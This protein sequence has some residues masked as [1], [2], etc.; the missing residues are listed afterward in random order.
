[1]HL[2]RRAFPILC[3]LLLPLQ[4]A[5]Q[6]P[7][8]LDA[9]PDVILRALSLEEK[10]GEMT[11]ITIQAVSSVKGSSTVAQQLDSARLEEFI[12]RRNVGSL[13]NVWD[14][15]L[16]PAQWVRFTTTIQRFASRRRVPVPVLFGIDAVHGHQYMTG[17]TIFPQNIAMAATWDPPLVAQANRITAMETRASGVAW[18]FAPVLDLGR[19]PL[20]SR[21]YETFGEDVLLATRMGTASV[22][23]LQHD[24]PTAPDPL[25]V[26]ASAKHFLGYS[27]PLNGRDRTTAWIP[28][29]QLREYFLPTFAA[30]INAGVQ[31]VMVNSGDVNGIPVHASRALLTDL[32]RTELGFTGVVI[33]DWEDIVRLQTVHRVARTRLDAVRMA[34]D[35]G[36][37]VS[38]V[39]YDV[40]FIDD[41]LSLV[42]SGAITE[43][44]VD[45][46][47]RRMIRLKLALG[48]FDH[49]G[50]WPARLADAN[51]ADSRAVSRR[52]AEEAITLLKNARGLL[53]LSHGTRVLVTGPAATSL[54]AQHGGW[55]Y[56][57]QGRDTTMY[58]AEVHTLLDA[59]RLSAGADH[60]LYRLGSTFSEPRDIA[61]AVA[62]ARQVDVAIIALGE[63]AVAEKPGDIEDLTLDAAQ[64]RL[65]QAIEATGTPVVIVLF[66]N[67]P[68]VI[69]DIVDGA[70]AVLTGYETGPY[71]G[72]AMA[73]VLFGEVNPS[74]KLPFTY[75]RRANDI[76]HYDRLASAEAAPDF[77]QNGYHPEWD[78]GH[79]LSYTEFTY[80]S[81]AIDRTPV[82]V[83]DSVTVRVTLRNAGRRQGTEVVQLYVRQL[84]ASVDPPM[85]R[86]RDFRR[87][88]LSPG[89]RATVTFRLPIQQLAF[90][91][92]DNRMT[93]EPGEFQLLVAGLRAPLVVQ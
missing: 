33:S 63:N 46:S 17:S 77:S 55:T 74:G 69:R 47:A 43:A 6:S 12:V 78:F 23:A 93:V 49:P 39:P 30:A 27:M 53:P 5:S 26:A 58:P 48:L 61:A 51:N 21:F 70:R 15:A 37:D 29:R 10:I 89:E 87:I 92:R 34:L 32:L 72:D 19:Q 68:R 9:R 31:T 65:A 85:R 66:E 20:W 71:G 13:L 42:H 73:A 45:S 24:A 25:V 83:H 59:V 88:T 40:S 86:L 36:I 4:L 28:E 2:A 91:G 75:P 80:E 62:A 54:P 64:L 18:N 57:W 7:A 67:R 84:V 1:M 82:G 81:L 90:V 38:M 56:T 79:G 8:T 52:A 22:L 16:S 41:V 3:V 11:Q 50:P 14:V 44:R 76:E 60:V 35:A